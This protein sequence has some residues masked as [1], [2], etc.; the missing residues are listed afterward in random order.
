LDQIFSEFTTVDFCE[1]DKLLLG[2][3]Y[4]KSIT[5]S[6]PGAHKVHLDLDISIIQLK[7]GF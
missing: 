6:Y 4:T 2:E 1:I 7:N 5:A 3:K